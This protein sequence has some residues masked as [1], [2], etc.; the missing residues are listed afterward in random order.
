MRRICVFFSLVNNI[1]T[2]LIE[3][4]IFK[5]VQAPGNISISLSKRLSST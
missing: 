2:L 5:C 1:L 3:L 4:F